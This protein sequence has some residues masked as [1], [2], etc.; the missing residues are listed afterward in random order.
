MSEVKKGRR[1]FTTAILIASLALNAV[2]IGYIGMH[3]WRRYEIASA[4]ATPRGLLRM[5]R[6]R[7]PSTDRPALDAAVQSKEGAIAAA[8]AEYQKALGAA[9]AQL[10]RP[11]FNE[12][13]FRAAVA[14]AREKRLAL[15]D[16]GLEIFLDAAT[17]ISPEGRQHLVP[18]RMLR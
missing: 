18:R 8:Q 10:T 15:A 7:L 9:I 12:A 2:L 11:D 17:H 5:V 14:V 1:R 4:N 6:W 13:D 3:A 16:L